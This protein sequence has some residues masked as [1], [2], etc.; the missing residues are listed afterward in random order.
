MAVAANTVET[1]DNSLIRDD[2]AEA[3]SSISPTECPFQQAAGV[4]E[5]CS[6]TY[7][8]WSVVA[9]ASPSTSNRVIEG[10]AAPAQDAGTLGKRR[11]N[12]TQISDKVVS[13][14]HTSNAVDAA[15]SNIQREAEQ[16]AI[17]LKEL[18]RD[19]ESMLTQN[20]AGA[21]GASGTARASAGFPNFIRTN[22]VLGA[23]GSVASLSGT[24][25]G[26]PNSTVTPGTAVPLAE[27]DFNDV[28]QAMW[29]A[30]AEVGLVL[31]GSNNKRVISQTFEGNATRYKDAIDKRLSAAVD[32]Y[33]SDFGELNIVPSR[34]LQTLA[35]VTYP[36]YFVDPAFVD[37]CFLETTRQKPLA[38]TGHTKERLIWQEYTL[39]VHNEAAHGM[40]AATTG[41][42]T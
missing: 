2:L 27:D 26:Y 8:E 28:C 11:G 33:D 34:F 13:T 38:E 31:V 32:V 40:I 23:A 10:D 21:A 6:S 36:V 30:G 19:V 37:V 3:Y 42:A 29:D 9:L 14:S 39:R 1:Y 35:S 17:K 20:I 4:G 7:K 15:A 12:Y 25:E 22:T 24:T 18:K 5:A 16:V 41:A